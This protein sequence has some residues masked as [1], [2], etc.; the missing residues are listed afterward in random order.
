VTKWI[1]KIFFLS[2]V[3]WR[4]WRT[5]WDREQVVGKVSFLPRS[6]P[7]HGASLE[8]LHCS[9]R[10]S[11]KLIQNNSKIV[12][13]RDIYGKKGRIK[14]T[15]CCPVQ[16]C[17]FD[18]P[19]TLKVCKIYPVTTC[20]LQFLVNCRWQKE[21]EYIKFIFKCE[22]LG[23]IGRFKFVITAKLHCQVAGVY[24]ASWVF[25]HIT[26]WWGEFSQKTQL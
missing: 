15:R 2:L 16:N 3:G 18:L 5:I 7:E 21:P 25:L 11:F 9:R 23:Y 13:P 8:N 17:P 12:Q 14:R 26:I 22:C 19:T 24:L 10:K 4:G 6:V 20:I 1:A